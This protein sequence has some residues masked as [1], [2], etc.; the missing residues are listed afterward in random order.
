MSHIYG[1]RENENLLLFADGVVICFFIASVGSSESLLLLDVAAFLA[2]TGD[3]FALLAVC[4]VGFLSFSS[5]ESESDDD[6]A[7]C[8]TLLVGVDTGLVA[9]VTFAIICF[10]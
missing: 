4:M 1:I 7:F 8:C 6:F 2:T 5:D 3:G 10:V 9:G